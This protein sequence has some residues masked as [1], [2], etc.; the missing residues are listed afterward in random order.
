MND[1][2]RSTTIAITTLVVARKSCP[3]KPRQTILA[4]FYNQT[5]ETFTG[6][7][8]LRKIQESSTGY[9]LYCLIFFDIL[10]PWWLTGFKGLVTAVLCGQLFLATTCY[11][12][13]P[14]H[15]LHVT[16]CRG[17]LKHG[18]SLS[19]LPDLSRIS[20]SSDIS[21]YDLRSSCVQNDVHDIVPP[22][23]ST[24]FPLRTVDYGGGF[25]RLDPSLP[26]QLRRSPECSLFSAPRTSWS[27]PLYD[28][29]PAAV[30]IRPA[31]LTA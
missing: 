16:L 23:S 3:R 12:Q 10:K 8:N 21:S 29:M 22:R 24:C 11:C 1:I 14:L 26:Q 18:R 30:R 27:L 17:L 5:I 31:A 13:T 6:Q 28:A 4:H 25:P 9:N 19:K 20:G 7:K 15:R 2:W